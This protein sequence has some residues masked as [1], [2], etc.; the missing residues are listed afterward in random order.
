MKKMYVLLLFALG[1]LCYFS[2]CTSE[3]YTGAITLLVFDDYNAN[4]VQEFDES[5][6]ENLLIVATDEDGNAFYGATNNSGEVTIS[7]LP[8]GVYT[9]SLGDENFTQ[10]ILSDEAI[11]VSILD[12]QMSVLDAPLPIVAAHNVRINFQLRNDGT[13]VAIDEALVNNFNQPYKLQTCQF[14]LSNIQALDA[15]GTASEIKDVALH[16]LEEGGVVLANAPIGSFTDIQFGLGVEPALNT[17]DGELDPLTA[18]E[19]GHPLHPLTANY[20][21]WTTG[22]IFTTLEGRIDYPDSTS[23]FNSFVYHLGSSDFYTPVSLERAFTVNEDEVTT[24]TIYIDLPTIWGGTATPINMLED[25]FTHTFTNTELATELA[26]NFGE[27]F[28]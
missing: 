15:A 20:W 21:D 16:K 1:S 14:Y 7:D 19:I 2:A 13:D 9:I 26:G 3:V 22:Y 17:D 12:G 18:Y 6:P 24:I 23:F 11:S 28:Y 25:H 10:T 8:N 5:T 27:A 4:G